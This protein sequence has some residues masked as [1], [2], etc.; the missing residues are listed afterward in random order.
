MAADRQCS[1]SLSILSSLIG[2]VIGIFIFVL[3]NLFINVVIYCTKRRHG[4][5]ANMGLEHESHTLA[6]P[7]YP[8]ANLTRRPTFINFETLPGHALSDLDR[9]IKLHH[10]NC[11]D[12]RDLEAQYL[13]STGSQGFDAL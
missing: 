8:F 4:L 10:V 12:V 2:L 6:T 9:D 5:N 11:Q 13:G 1:L 7:I 3:L